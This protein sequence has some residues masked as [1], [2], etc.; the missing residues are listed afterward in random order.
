MDFPGFTLFLCDAKQVS[1]AH[2]F[3]ILN[4]NDWISKVES[5]DCEIQ[6]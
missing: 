2:T 4:D 3:I 5:G 1:L 6:A